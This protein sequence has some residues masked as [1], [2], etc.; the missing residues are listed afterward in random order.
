MAKRRA[1]DEIEWSVVNAL[2]KFKKDGASV[3]QISME[4]KT[5]WKTTNDIIG[6][7]KRW[8][9]IRLIRA[10]KRLKVYKW[11]V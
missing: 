11:K 9:I 6:R 2:K 3:S 5:N 7:L 8:G 1:Y 10:D 4:A